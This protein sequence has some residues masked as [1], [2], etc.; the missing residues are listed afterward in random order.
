MVVKWVS[1]V[2]GV[3]HQVNIKGTSR[4]CEGDGVKGELEG[5]SLAGATVSMNSDNKGGS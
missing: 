5:G 2:V 1:M 4:A 3:Y